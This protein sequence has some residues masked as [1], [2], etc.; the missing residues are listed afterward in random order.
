MFL[1]LCKFVPA[2]PLADASISLHVVSADPSEAFALK[3]KRLFRPRGVEVDICVAYTASISLLPI[4]AQIFCDYLLLLHSAISLWGAG[5]T[6]GS[7]GET[8]I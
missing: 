1:A 5:P 3:I 2:S 6:P 4:V 8:C 7:K